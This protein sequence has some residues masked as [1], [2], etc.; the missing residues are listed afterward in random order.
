VTFPI[1][2]SDM[3][4]LFKYADDTNLL[5]P[6]NTNVDLVDEFLP[7]DAMHKRGI[8]RHPVSVCPSVR[9]VRELRQND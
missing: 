1:T 9:N 7:R 6:E 3:N 2:L 4:L 8:C 5:V